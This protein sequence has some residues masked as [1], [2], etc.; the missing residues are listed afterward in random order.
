M[1]EYIN[2]ARSHERKISQRHFVTEHTSTME[3]FDLWNT[4]LWGSV[5][6]VWTSELTD[7]IDFSL[8]MY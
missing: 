4:I 5:D 6:G 2:D 7:F 1:F 3:D 8:R